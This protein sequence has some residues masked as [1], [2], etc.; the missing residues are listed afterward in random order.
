MHGG[1]CTS[2]LDTLALLTCCACSVHV[3]TWTL[4]EIMLPKALA[5]ACRGAR[6]GGKV[7]RAGKSAANGAH[8]ESGS[9]AMLELAAPIK[10]P[11]KLMASTTCC[12]RP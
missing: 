12:K 4:V 2:S 11:V 7:V 9:D 3:T 1:G 6:G 10:H 8:C 5:A